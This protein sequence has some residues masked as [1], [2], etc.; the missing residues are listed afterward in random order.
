MWN[1]AAFNQRRKMVRGSLRRVFA[2]PI[3]VLEAAGIEPTLRA[4]DLTTEDYLALARAA[5]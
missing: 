1:A 5:A 4:E 2:D 3:R